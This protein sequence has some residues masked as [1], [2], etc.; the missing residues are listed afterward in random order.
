[1]RKRILT[2]RF[3]RDVKKMIKRGKDINKLAA[4]M[5]DLAED[6]PLP[7]RLRDHLLTGNRVGQRECHIEND[8][9][10]I[11]TYLDDGAVCFFETGTHADLF[12]DRRP[13]P[14]AALLP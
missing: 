1:M 8:W 5:D 12:A 6:N 4:V 3:N 14:F 9:L 7:A 10:L 13:L 11:Y 2:K